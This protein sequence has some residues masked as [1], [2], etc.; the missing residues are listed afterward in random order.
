[1][2]MFENLF[3]ETWGFC[4]DLNMMIITRMRMKMRGS[5]RKTGTTKRTTSRRKMI[6]LSS[7]I[8]FCNHKP[9]PISMMM[10]GI[11]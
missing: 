10:L 8:T 5:R 7:V 4:E 3:L 2:E 1:M 11:K 9:K 6:K